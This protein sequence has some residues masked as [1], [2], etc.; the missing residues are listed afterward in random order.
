MRLNNALK[1]VLA[2]V[3]LLAASSAQA[4]VCTWIGANSNGWN[5]NA[6]WSCTGTGGAP[7]NGDDLVFPASA[8]NKVHT[9]NRSLL[10]LVNSIT[11]NGCGYN[12]TGALALSIVSNNPISV[13]CDTLGASNA[14]DIQNLVFTSPPPIRIQQQTG[15]VAPGN[16]TFNLGLTNAVR[17][18]GKLDFVQ[19]QPGMT[20]PIIRVKLNE[21]SPST[22]NQITVNGGRVVFPSANSYSGLTTVVSGELE[23]LH[24]I[25]LGLSDSAASGTIVRSNGTLIKGP[26]SINGEF[27][28]LDDNLNAPGV[29]NPLLFATGAGNWSGQVTLSGPVNGSLQPAGGFASNASVSWIVSGV[30]AGAADIEIAAKGAG[31]SLELTGTNNYTGTT[32]ILNFGRLTVRTPAERIP[33]TSVVDIAAGGVFEFLPLGGSVTETIGG[34]S[35]LGDVYFGGS[36]TT[37][38]LAINVANGQSYDFGGTITDQSTSIPVEINGPGRQIISG[39][40]TSAAPFTLRNSTIFDVRGALFPI[41]KL[42]DSAILQTGSLGKVLGVQP[43]A[44]VITAARVRP[45]GMGSFGIL[46]IS[47]SSVLLHPNITLEFD[48]AGNVP[49]VNQDKIKAAASGLTVD[50]NSAKL[51]VNITTDLSPGQSAGFLEA[52][53]INGPFTGYPEGSLYPSGPAPVKYVVSYL[54]GKFTLTRPSAITL[55]TGALSGTIGQAFSAPAL[56]PAGGVT[57]Y[58]IS[59][60]SGPGWLTGTQVGNT[61]P[62][63]GTVAAPVGAQNFTITVSDSAGQSANFPL[64]ITVSGGAPGDYSWTGSVDSAWSTPMNWTPSGPPTTASI[65]RFPSGPS[66][67]VINNVPRISLDYLQITDGYTLAGP[68]L[69]TLKNGNPIRFMGS[70]NSPARLLVPM[71]LSAPT[72]VV[73]ATAVDPVIASLTLGS[74]LGTLD[75]AG[76]IRFELANSLA[77]ELG[78]GYVLLEPF[79]KDTT[80]SAGTVTYQRMTGGSAHRVRLANN[81]NY[82]GDTIFNGPY[83]QVDT[84]DLTAPFGN[85]GGITQT[86]VNGAVVAMSSSGANYTIPNERLTLNIFQSFASVLASF[87]PAAS[88]EQSWMGEIVVPAFATIQSVGGVLR[89]SSA[90]S[91]G[92]SVDF[93][94]NKTIILDAACSV[95]DIKIK[96]GTT[97]LLANGELIPNNSIVALEGN[98]ILDLGGNQETIG[99]LSGADP[100]SSVNVA[101]NST[102]VGRLI[103]MGNATFAGVIFGSPFAPGID[104]RVNNPQPLL[105][106]ANLGGSI[107]VASGTQILTGNSTFTEPAEVVGG[108]LELRGSLRDV[109]ING[110]VFRASALGSVAVNSLATANSGSTGTLALRT[111]LNVATTALINAPII[112][113]SQVD[114]DTPGKLSVV[115]NVNI[116]GASL[117]LTPTGTPGLGYDLI[118]ITGMGLVTGTFNGLANNVIIMSGGFSFRINYSAKKVTITRILPPPPDVVVNTTLDPGDSSN[119]SLRKALE[120]V[121]LNGSIPSNSN[122]TA[123]AS[124]SRITF[125]PAVFAVPQTITLA[126]TALAVQRSVIIDGPGA[127]LLTISALS[128]SRVF[129]I[130]DGQQSN[131]ANVAIYGLNLVNGRAQGI[132]A[133]GGAIASQEHLMLGGVRIANSSVTFIDAMPGLANGGAVAMGMGAN[134]TVDDSLFESNQA[135]TATMDAFAKGG[136]IYM[137]GGNLALSNSTLTNNT[138]SVTGT[139]SGPTA[140]AAIGGAIYLASGSTGQIGSSTLVNN[141]TSAVNASIN[142]GEFESRGGGIAVISSTIAVANS[143]LSNLTLNPGSARTNSPDIFNAGVAMVDY[144]YIASPVPLVTV[145]NAVIGAPLLAALANNGGATDTI[146]F[147]SG[148]SLRDAGNPTAPGLPF[149]QRGPGFPRVFGPRVDVG[150]FELQMGALPTLSV[151]DVSISGDNAANPSLNFLVTLSAP[152]ASDVSFTVNTSTSDAEASDYTAISNQSV[153]IPAGMTT[154]T[155]SVLVT[156]DSIVEPIETIHLMLSAPV[157]ATI[158]IAKGIGTILNDDKAVISVSSVSSALESLNATI[159]ISTSNAIEGLASVS[160]A[161]VTGTNPDPFQNATSDVDFAVTP[162]TAMLASGSVTQVIRVIEDSLVEAPEQ[163]RVNLTSVSPPSGISASDISLA[164]TASTHVH[165]ILNNDMTNLSTTAAS[166]IE[167]NSGTAQLIFTV[168]LSVPAAAP[169]QA[170]LSTANFGTN[171]ADAADYSSLT[172]LV[173]NFNPG[174]TS[175]TVSIEVVSDD[176]VEANE[177]LRVLLSDPALPIATITT[178]AVT[179]T[180]TNDD[181]A[182]LSISSAS[183]IEGN[184]GTTPMNFLLNLSQPVQGGVSVSFT[185][186]NGTATA[187]SDFIA[188]PSTVNFPNLSLNAGRS[189][190]IVGDT[191]FE[192]DETFSVVLGA[193]TLP[194]G[195]S[196]VTLSPTSGIGTIINDDVGITTTVLSTPLLTAAF[197]PGITYPVSVTVSASSRPSGSVVVSATRQGLPAI[198]PISCALNLGNGVNP[199]ELT[200]S[201]NLSPTSPGVWATSVSFTGTGGFNNSSASANAVFTATLAPF[202][203]AQSLNPTVV[204]QA[205]SVTVSASAAFGGPTPTGLIQV[206]QF[207]GGI[208]ASAAMASGSAVVNLFSRSPVVKGLLIAYTDSTGVYSAQEQFIEHITNPAPTG[209]SASLSAAQGGANQPVVVTYT[210]GVIAPGAVPP[211]LSGPTGQVQVSDGVT[212][213][214]CALVIPTGSCSLSPS[215][216]GVRQITARYLSDASYLGS[217]SPPLPYTVQQGTGSVDLI[218]SIGNGVRVINGSQVIYTIIVQNLGNT[219]VGAASITN[220]LPAGAIS[221]SFTCIAAAGSSC[222]AA[223]GSGP[224]AQTIDVASSG[225]VAY[226]VVVELAPGEG[227][228]SNT[229]TVTT[230]AGIV[231]A[232]PANNT[233]SDIDP[234]GIFGTGFEDEIE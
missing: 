164:P 190:S 50:I 174:V 113:D 184:S 89:L 141:R 172:N 225:S 129:F 214:N 96:P 95:G 167:G 218:V 69:M 22:S 19:T 15:L 121:A 205:F 176:I 43:F 159:T 117:I 76:N 75:F 185:P 118:N 131:Y 192:P 10:T 51:M 220:A 32:R 232:N 137:E 187:P 91:G 127:R 44:G 24:A 229:V 135:S 52:D 104:P 230:P 201:C 7:N 208:A 224:I 57:P 49:G 204:G 140:P 223:S 106:P 222:G 197:A 162:G 84:Q 37:P 85:S 58:T 59:I 212:S 216:L 183:L 68:G 145:T 71:L 146:A 115:G 25:G 88:I 171:P 64:S 202:T 3:A 228:V 11:I 93:G 92:G 14:I 83:L 34:L 94:G 206:T 169:V 38:L 126:G 193:L 139:A 80:A 110:G 119:C 86:I 120:A 6:N 74:G 17:W 40:V 144:S 166:V 81:T 41:V 234:R 186:T 5:D 179:G 60:L 210:L 231:D 100:L 63:S 55:S 109:V 154:A 26:I 73:T 175:T 157:G 191:V 196:A 150:A 103:T 143:V 136:A 67:K 8:L 61:L 16:V 182:T 200:G 180:I 194:P 195:V 181:S 177:T 72:A 23:V 108:T 123:G 42:G 213:A 112:I 148:S 33:N 82:S 199:N 27:L 105:P 227:S 147:S 124:G 66:N 87:A 114:A 125:D 221:Q 13:T 2:L 160:Y 39:N 4:F 9:H 21:F 219:T 233:A 198:A 99:A 47:G 54:G 203:F 130:D 46:E 122:C 178:P 29:P 158:S 152:S 35:G 132:N 188:T 215:T 153:T 168:T 155:V 111:R 1:N 70:S 97:L 163:F 31:S 189:V 28:T 56:A 18:S 116:S 102:T 173:V 156:P 45:G 128:N 20:Q 134:L 65:V 165:T 36:A 107:R 53:T 207:P 149:D 226:R 138:A 12:I 30:I 133:Y 90:I 101:G 217:T 98:A 78:T 79:L 77:A 142:T 161:A 62:L 170:L 209:M 211:G 48:M 151:N